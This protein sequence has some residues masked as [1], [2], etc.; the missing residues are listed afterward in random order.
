MHF[1]PKTQK[2]QTQN[3][4]VTIPKPQHVSDCR[5]SLRR[6]HQLL[7][8]L[9]PELLL[10]LHVSNEQELGGISNDPIAHDLLT[11]SV[12]RLWVQNGLGGKLQEQATR[13]QHKR[14]HR[15]VAGLSMKCMKSPLTGLSGIDAAAAAAAAAD[16]PVQRLQQLP[17]SPM[18]ELQLRGTTRRVKSGIKKK[19]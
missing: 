11:W 14:S 15:R 4:K 17:M 3:P 1:K 19:Q 2:S 9:L 8:L 7:L 12:F 16:I 13:L 18:P 10:I 5:G 6:C